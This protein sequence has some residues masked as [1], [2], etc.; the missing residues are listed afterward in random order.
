MFY[1]MLWVSFGCLAAWATLSEVAKRQTNK[2][3][4]EPVSPT[5]VNKFQDL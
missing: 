3:M 4:V 5:V 1:A 2:T